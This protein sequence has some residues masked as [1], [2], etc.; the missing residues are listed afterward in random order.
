MLAAKKWSGEIFN[1]V[2]VLAVAA[3]FSFGTAASAATLPTLGDT[4][5]G[6]YDV[7]SVNTGPNLHRFWRQGFAATK[8]RGFASNGGS[9]DYRGR[10][11]MVAGR[12]RLAGLILEPTMA[13]EGGKYPPRH[14]YGAS[15]K[16]LNE[17]DLTTR[18]S[19][20]V[21]DGPIG[22]DEERRE[23]GGSEREVTPVP[24]PATLPLMLAAL[25]LLGLIARR[26]RVPA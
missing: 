15:N 13:P 16:D 8:Y 24:L 26:R 10:M 21:S 11:A 4:Y 22:T 17:F 7:E 6:L 1:R 12:D 3:A 2:C 18:L 25:G 5:E 9:F 14:G 20:N 19:L 23:E